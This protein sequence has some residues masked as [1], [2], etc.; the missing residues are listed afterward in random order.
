MSADKGQEFA[1][2]LISSDRELRRYISAFLLRQDDVEAATAAILAKPA[3]G[4]NV[5]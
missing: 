2:L 4:R 5:A 1:R 3:N